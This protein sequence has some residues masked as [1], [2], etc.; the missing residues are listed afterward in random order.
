VRLSANFY[1]TAQGLRFTLAEPARR[2][3]LRRLPALNLE[4]AAEERAQAKQT[5]GAPKPK[6]AS[7]LRKPKA[8]ASQGGLLE[9]NPRG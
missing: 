4:R 1:D 7:A 6:H 5:A 2:V 9:Q 8:D 3:V